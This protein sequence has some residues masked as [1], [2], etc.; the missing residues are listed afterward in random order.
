MPT[1][2]CVLGRG[3]TRACGVRWPARAQCRGR[4]S[5][6]GRRGTPGSTPRRADDFRVLVR[7]WSGVEYDACVTLTRVL[8]LPRRLRRP[9]QTLARTV[10]AAFSRP[11]PNQDAVLVRRPVLGRRLCLVRAEPESRALRRAPCDQRVEQSCGIVVEQERVGIVGLYE[12]GIDAV[13]QEFL[14]L[15]HSWEAAKR[16]QPA[17]KRRGGCRGQAP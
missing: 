1:Q 6:R 3:R 5:R 17:P 14:S 7:R 2:D 15:G 9:R 10:N 11:S 8:R 4:R 13:R 16:P 12:S